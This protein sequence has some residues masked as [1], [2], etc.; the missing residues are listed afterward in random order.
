[1]ALKGLFNGLKGLMALKGLSK[2]VN[3]LNKVPGGVSR[4][5]SALIRH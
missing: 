3:D 2:V 1:M 4:L 5:S